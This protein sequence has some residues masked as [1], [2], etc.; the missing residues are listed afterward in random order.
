MT[1][2]ILPNLSI[3]RGDAIS[4][5]EYNEDILSIYQ[6]NPLI[7][8]LPPIQ[9][10]DSAVRRLAYY[11]AYSENDRTLLSHERY[12]LIDHARSF[13]QPL[14]KH[15]QLEH[16]VSRMIRQGYIAR[17]PH[18]KDFWKNHRD[19]V[20]AFS[21]GRQTHRSNATS[22][23]ILGISGI[24]KTT[25]IEN[26]LLSYPQVVYHS[27]YKGDYLDLHQIVWLKLE[28]P[29]GADLRTL[30]LTFFQAIDN[31]LGTR[32]FYRYT[33][34]LLRP[35]ELLPAMARLASTHALGL[36]VID[37]LQVL[38]RVKEPEAAQELLDFFVSL[39]NTIGLPVV[40]IGTFKAMPLL[41][42]E[43]RQIRR[44]NG[45]GDFI[46]DRMY[47][48]QPD[49]EQ[50]GKFL[51]DPNNVGELLENQDWIFF[52]ESLWRY[53]YTRQ[54]TALTR[55]LR[56][57]LYEE[58]QGI[59]DYAV[60]LYFLAQNHAI[61]TGLEKVTVGL[62]RKVARERLRMSQPTLKIL[63]DISMAG[64]IPSISELRHI[65]D[66][67]P[68]DFSM[69]ARTI[70]V[71]PRAIIA[72]QQQSTSTSENLQSL[73]LDPSLVIDASEQ[74]T[75]ANFTA[76]GNSYQNLVESNVIADPNEWDNE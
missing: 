37:E 18:Q 33:G 54:K 75:L 76:Q 28:T 66:I 11:P 24:G 17:N 26:I 57:V 53:Q 4:A 55:K 22:M 70:P 74:P 9:D 45:Q 12:H 27:R 63:R 58:T 8:C 47:Q 5:P 65:E 32:H 6:G 39:I 38:A 50:L 25:A 20:R 35:S 60:K 43:F 72:P 1:K 48:Y 52:T 51:T 41:S 19:N 73:T 40:V 14:D 15:V 61:A 68:L 64:R 13:F 62:L 34:R 31:L 7:E 49:P 69:D 67:I 30:C 42:N 59:T 71:R 2:P 16:S 3:L 23:A 36:L 10:Y 56:N 44:M 29:S 21:Q 46:W